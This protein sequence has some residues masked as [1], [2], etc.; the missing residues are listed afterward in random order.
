MFYRTA[1]LVFCTLASVA[2]H[3][4]EL[5]LQIS[6]GHTAPKPASFY[7][8]LVGS[9]GVEVRDAQQPWQGTA[10]GGTP[11]SRA[12]TLSFPKQDAKPI[13]NL[14][15]IWADLIAHSDADTVRRLTEDPA[16]RI[17]PRKLTIQLNAEGTRGF[18]LTV[19]QLLRNKTFWIPSLDVYVSA[20]DAPPSFA[21]HQ[22]A[23]EP[24]R[25]RRIL[26]RIHSEPEA[27]YAQY[28]G[29]WQDMGSPNYIHPSQ[30][31]PGHIVCLTWDGSIAKFGIDRGAGIWNDY[32]NPDRFRF[33][34]E[35]SNLTEGIGPYWK[36]QRLAD[37]LPVITTTLERD[38]L[39]YEVEQF[40]Y[41]LNGPPAKRTG[42]IEMVLLSRVK[43]TDL[44]GRARTVPVTMTHERKLSPELDSELI[45]EQ[46]GD[47]MLFLDNGKRNA[48]LAVQGGG[49]VTWS[50]VNEHGQTM[51]RL[52]LTV[53]LDLPAGGSR[54]F[55]VALPS[56]VVSPAGR[57]ALAA[58]DYD[59]ARAATLKFWSDY[60]ARGAWFN[61]P[62]KAVNDLFRATLW[63][64]LRLP[65]RHSDGDIDLPYS[66]FA[67]DQTG[68]PWPVNQAVYVDYM[69]YGLRGYQQVAAE[70]L[71]AIYR[72]NQEYGGHVNGFANW[73]AYTPGM[74]YTVAQNY[75]LS[76]DRD[77]F[78]KSLPATLKALDWCLEQVRGAK[79]LVAGPLNDGTGRGYWAFNQAYLYAGIDLL[80]KALARIGHPR[81]QECLDTAK[82]FR[83][84]VERGFAASSTESP[85]VE[86]RDHTWIPYVPCEATKYGR[87]L[88]I[89][90]PSDVDTGAVHMLRLQA[91]PAVGELADS[92][93]NDHEDNLFLHGWGIAN[94]PVYNQH[95]TAYLL[96]DDPKAVIRTF[97]SYMAS[98]FSHSVFESVEHRWRWGQYFGPPSTDGAWFELYRNMLVRELD[99]QTLLIGQATPRAWLE[100]G[101]N[102]EVK[103]APTWFG[104]VSYRLV[105]GT[106]TITA[107]I[108][109]DARRP[110]Q[111]ILLRLRHPESKRFRQVTVNGK[112]WTDVD[113]DKDWIKLPG[114]GARTY[115]VVATY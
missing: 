55:S 13:E 54:E 56:A 31:L 21:D 67:Y 34:F 47:R 11:G 53:S 27:A 78:E 45:T 5:K 48:L 14:Q 58:L 80:G 33:W 24:F 37:G 93:L 52:D 85:L 3:A 88:D 2:L 41:P 12:F 65:R 22:R 103:N 29:L 95:A 43:L 15:V 57:K 94:E 32:G 50:G 59:A 40:A 68:T 10:G 18:S 73:L 61:V 87:L 106:D 36:G 112:P 49:N 44:E 101:K 83:A 1:I 19:D 113:P 86:L 99:D 104:N 23:I 30:P 107:V 97:Y 77:T 16:W 96:R 108:D 115:Q 17:D 42:E 111:S 90:Y 82:V 6:L 26:D 28:T 69:L 81:A 7:V 62:E 66:N 38:G 89:W 60:V 51:K 74:I 109:L 4:D 100:P 70:E 63:H 91:V 76:G 9:G 79:G 64:A 20:G 39:R 84:A 92:L 35:F 110:P 72:N 98:A 75:L 25:G 114:S 102:I 105:G 71:D 46:Q 8:R